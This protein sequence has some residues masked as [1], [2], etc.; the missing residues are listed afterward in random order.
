MLR[1]LKIL[2]AAALISNSAI[3]EGSANV[4]IR[5][6]AGF[7]NNVKSSLY[8][9]GYDRYSNNNFFY[10]V[11]LGT[12]LDP[13]EEHRDAIYGAFS[14]GKRFGETTDLHVNLS[15]GVLFHSGS[16]VLLGS[17]FQFTEELSLGYDRV[18]VGVKHISSAGLASPNRSRDTLFVEYAI[19]LW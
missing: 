16:D 8:S 18:S 5:A 4:F 11:D 2:I 12:W 13:Q 7:T 6:G 14:G 17:A 9:V 1:L 19:P 15:V 3:A 10:R